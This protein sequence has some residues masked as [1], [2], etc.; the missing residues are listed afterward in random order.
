MINFIRNNPF[1]F[2]TLTCL[3]FFISAG[4]FFGGH[5][6]NAQCSNF[7]LVSTIF[8]FIQKEFID[9]IIVIWVTL[10]SLVFYFFLY[11][12]DIFLLLIETLLISWYAIKNKNSLYHISSI[13]ISLSF[14]FHLYYIQ[15]TKVDFLQHD[16][17]GIITYISK[18]SENGLNWKYFNPWYMYY[19]FHQPL[20]FIL[21]KLVYTI[22]NTLWDAYSVAYEGLQYLSLFYVTATTIFIARILCLFRFSKKTYLALLILISFNPTLFLFSGYI[23]NDV[24]VLF[25][26]VFVIYYILMWYKKDSIK[27]ILLS[28][29][30]FGFGV[31]SKLSMLLYAPCISLF[32]LFKLL[33]S[34]HKEKTI[35][36]ISL[37]VIIAVPLSLL[38]IVRNHILFDMQFYNIPSTSPG[39]QNFYNLSLFDRLTDF[40]ML[41]S[42]FMN[43]PYVNDANMILAIIKTELF[44]EWDLR[45][46]SK[47]IEAAATIIYLI[48]IVIKLV[49]L[50]GFIILTTNKSTYNNAYAILFISIWII[51]WGY[52]IKYTMEL[53]YICSSDYRLFTLIMLAESFIIGSLIPKNKTAQYIILA[54]S[55]IYAAM[56]SYIYITIS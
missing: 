56:S 27:H 32:F 3:L 55:I 37:F 25:W 19:T 11:E 41:S 2:L 7:I 36:A 48:N 6:I 13:I 8:L 31:L 23:S 12:K 5:Y 22:G 28:A 43:V 21:Q 49:S 30:G 15:N 26:S 20:N 1:C 45:I 10:L 18:I 53:P 24:A 29:I 4:M 38:W 39:G 9:R 35:R 33:K 50:L 52:I 17:T 16:L 34:N 46:F 40:S 14:I 54:V 47:N 42:P 44:G 51:T